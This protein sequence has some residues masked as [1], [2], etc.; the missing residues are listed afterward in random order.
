MR[1]GKGGSGAMPDYQQIFEDNRGSSL[2]TLLAMYKG[3][4]LKLALSILFFIIKHSPVWA[5]PI[6][7]S[8]VINCVTAGAAGEMSQGD[9]AGKIMINVAVMIVLILQ[10]VPSNYVHTYFYAK[11]IRQVE[12]ELRSAMVR[13]LQELSIA[14]HQKMESGRIQSKIMRDVEQIETLSS[15]VFISLLSIILNIVVAAAVVMWNNR[16]V[17]LFFAATIPIAVAVTA[18][19]KGRIS[20]YN[21]EFRQ[22]MEE[23]SVQ[24]ME[25]VEMIPV[26]RA[27]ALEERE[28]SK[29]ERR[30]ERVADSGFRLDMIQTYF[31]S[32]SWIVFQL[33]QV[34]C[35]TFT[36]FM[37]F[38]GYITVG[39]V[40]MYQSY[41]SSI[42]GGITNI[43][44]LIPVISK[45]LESVNSVG[46][47]LLSDDLEELRS[48]TKVIP[49]RGEIRFSNVGFSYRGGEPVFSGVSFTARP[50]ETVA[51]VGP[52]GAGKTTI[53]NLVIG[54]AKATEGT[55]TID[56][57]D[58][59]ELKMKNY[60]EHLAVVPQNSILFQGTIRE[61]ITYGLDD[62]SE[63]MLLEA[64][65]AAN[66]E[67]MVS[68]LPDGLDTVISEHGANLSGG[69]R[70][71]IS[72]ARAF[73]RN[74]RILILDEA[75][76]ALDAVSERQI[77]EA[78]ANLSKDRTTLIV[79]HRLSTVRDADK[80]AVID[81]GGLREIGTYDEL[82]EKRGA[83]YHL[84]NV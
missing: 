67:E 19:F 84:Q 66:L 70:Q 9:A 28:A 54:F 61:N 75:T 55:V 51:F 36:S 48:G 4:Y 15:Q 78:T 63:E 7:I 31:G 68:R 11:A 29:M 33:F 34:V 22:E 59:C 35:L 25:M 12:R 74:P 3:K 38:K 83:F 32:V 69:Q 39:D 13:R 20:S 50:G 40:T 26:T 14:F 8:N 77:K 24:V 41:F 16:I 52:S 46:D 37:A 56:G 58:I 42:V 5:M 10:N 53:L 62:V 72:I 18:Y 60:R 76:S 81:Q 49:V 73:V 30:L 44:G 47:I 71:R 21:R 65:R 57:T 64:V 23:T 80:I 17:F 79:A 82:M 45:G 6:A 43:V 1:L 2:R 27:H